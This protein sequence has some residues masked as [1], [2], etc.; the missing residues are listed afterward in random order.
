M[1]SDFN[2]HSTVKATRKP[3]TCDH[4]FKRIEVGQ[5]A[6]RGSGVYD[7]DFYCSYFHTECNDWGLDYATRSGMWR[8]EFV[9]LHQIGEFA[10]PDHI[11][12]LKHIIEHYP[13]VAEHIGAAASL[14]DYETELDA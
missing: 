9:F 4:C 12:E 14:K 2:C 13:K 5:P 8:E 1:S 10:V 7:G 3:H 11:A 6:V